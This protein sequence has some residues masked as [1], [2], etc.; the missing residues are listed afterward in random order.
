M[1]LTTELTIVDATLRNNKEVLAYLLAGLPTDYDPFIISM[2][3]KIEPL[4]ID[5]V[6][7]HLDAFEASQLQR[8]AELQVQHNDSANY[9]GRSGPSHGRGHD[10]R[11]YGSASSPGDRCG[12]NPPLVAISIASSTTLPQSVGTEWKSH[13]IMN[14]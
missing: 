7:A 9:M 13:T 10:G 1:G 8:V 5:C 11:F 6:F 12:S 14:L 2:M 4:S 3:T